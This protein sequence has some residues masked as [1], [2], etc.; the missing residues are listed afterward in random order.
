M[1][2]ASR[3]MPKFIEKPTGLFGW[4]F[5]L[6][7]LGLFFW[8]VWVVPLV[9]L[10]APV[11]VYVEFRNKKERKAHFQKILKDRDNDSICTFSRHFECREIDTWVIRAVYEQLQSYLASEQDYF[12]I[13]ATDNVLIDLRIDD[14]V[15][16]FDLIEEI[17]ERTGRTI[18]ASESNPYYGKVNTVEDLIYFFNLQPALN[19][20]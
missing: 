19:A 10:L 3:F 17:A 18:D 1:K 11:L 14:D 16:E 6:G 20:V 2:K 13:R 9:L 5:I 7:I 15:F 12:P 8:F 4:A